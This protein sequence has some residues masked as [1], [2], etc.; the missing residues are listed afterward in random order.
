MVSDALARFGR[1]YK[2][3]LV[4]DLSCSRGTK[5]YLAVAEK[6]YEGAICTIFDLVTAKKRKTLSWPESD[7]PEFLCVAFSADSKYLIT[8]TG[9]SPSAARVAKRREQRNRTP[10]NTSRIHYDPLN[11]HIQY[12]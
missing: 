7:A 3:K 10:H 6:C 8:Q 9:R 1:F 12:I 5:R 4:R 2:L 11:I